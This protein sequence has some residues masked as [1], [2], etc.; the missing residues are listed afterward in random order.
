VTTLAFTNPFSF[1][2]GLPPAHDGQLWWDLNFSFDSK[3]VP[4]VGSVLGEA[5]L[6]MVPTMGG[7]GKGGSFAT[8]DALLAAY[9]DYL[10][11]HFAKVA[12]TDTWT[13]Y[14]RAAGP[15]PLDVAP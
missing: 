11:R 4:P 3:H 13:L 6:V 9:G 10:D 1:A 2:L 8:V 12:Q 5:S 7:R 15:R 14:R